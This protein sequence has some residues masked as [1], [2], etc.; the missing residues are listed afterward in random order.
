MHTSTQLKIYTKKNTIIDS[1]I[2]NYNLQKFI[3]NHRSN[4]TTAL[5]AKIIRNGFEK[6]S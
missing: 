3:S 6:E 1:I 5:R 4:P 2:L